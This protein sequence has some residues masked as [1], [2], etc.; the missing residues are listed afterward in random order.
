[1]LHLARLEA[2]AAR[3]VLHEA[4]SSVL[5]SRRSNL[6]LRA[7]HEPL[8]ER[9]GRDHRSGRRC[10]GQRHL[11]RS[12]SG[13]ADVPAVVEPAGRSRRAG[14]GERFAQPHAPLRPDHAAVRADHC[15]PAH[16]P[17]GV[18]PQPLLDDVFRGPRILRLRGRTAHAHR[19]DLHGDRHLRGRGGGRVY[20]R[21]H[22]SRPAAHAAHQAITGDRRR[23]RA[24]ARRGGYAA[25]RARRIERRCADHRARQRDPVRQRSGERG[26]RESAD[27]SAIR[28]PAARRHARSRLPARNALRRRRPRAPS[29]TRG[30]AVR[31]HGARAL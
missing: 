27:P 4:G 15:Q 7:R 29:R 21:R 2:V 5:E 20:G 26:T 11:R 16:R 22:R 31:Q 12:A 14:A 13:S 10:D 17:R 24:P 18:S 9:P 28:E 25:R 6:R 30:A 3:G 1:M 8:D 19:V 23:A